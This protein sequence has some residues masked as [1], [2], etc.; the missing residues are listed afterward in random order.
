MMKKLRIY[1]LVFEAIFRPNTAKK[2]S[3]EGKNNTHTIFLD[4][5]YDYFPIFHDERFDDK[6]PWKKKE[7]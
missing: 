5:N 6:S 4:L 1:E 2:E 3:V 7:I